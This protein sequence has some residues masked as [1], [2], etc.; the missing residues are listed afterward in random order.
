MRRSYMRILRMCWSLCMAV[1]LCQV[2][3][4]QGVATGDLHI[5]VKDPQGGS[6]TNAT[7]VARDQAKGAERVAS[8]SGVGEYDLLALP[9]SSYTITVAASGFASATAQDVAVTVG[10]SANMPIT[11][12]VAGSTESVT[13][14]SEAALIET[15]RTSTTD[16]V[17]QKRIDNLPING[18]NYINFTLT[19]SQVVRDNAPNTGAA[20]TSGLNIER[21]A[22]PLESRERGWRRRD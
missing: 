16:T 10:G 12:R 14:S 8:A 18:R 7:V 20:P 6:V 5:I 9:P 22:R 11:L 21:P 17:D 19:D 4:A 15:A 1:L 3:F 2:A 13:V